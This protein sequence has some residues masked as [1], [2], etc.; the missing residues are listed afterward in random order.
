[1]TLRRVG[2]GCR[3]RDKM[4]WNEKK[5]LKKTGDEV[6]NKV[7]VQ[8]VVASSRHTFAVL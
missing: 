2:F 8:W 4:E 5:Y 3:D 7:H 6:K 1:M